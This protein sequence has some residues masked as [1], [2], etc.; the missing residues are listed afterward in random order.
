MGGL[1]L[2]D[3]K[4][5]QLSAHLKYIADWI[6]NNASSV[7]LDIEKSLSN[8]PLKNQL[9]IDKLK[10]IKKLYSNPVTIQTVRAW[11]ITQHMEGRSGLVLVFTPITDNSDFLPGTLDKAFK[12]WTAKGIF[13]PLDLFNGPILMTFNQVMEKYGISRNDLFRYFQVRD[14][15]IKDTWLLADMKCSYLRR[16]LPLEP[17]MPV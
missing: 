2:P 12:C 10:C 11:R 17:F 15:I 16:M 8:C 3:I 1:D 9:V 4:R 13:L 14:F 6:E 5:Y 7:W